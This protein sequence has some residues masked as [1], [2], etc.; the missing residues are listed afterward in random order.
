MVSSYEYYRR[1]VID[2][3]SSEN[4]SAST[5]CFVF[6]AES[7]AAGRVIRRV[8]KVGRR[9]CR[10]TDMGQSKSQSDQRTHDQLRLR[11]ICIVEHRWLPTIE[12]YRLAQ[13]SLNSDTAAFCYCHQNVYIQLVTV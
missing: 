12:L 11:A 10:Y 4:S 3:N 9:T 6:A 7:A 13:Y 2:G 5:G 1:N 8:T